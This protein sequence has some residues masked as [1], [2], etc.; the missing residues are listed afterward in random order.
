MRFKTLHP[1][2]SRKSKVLIISVIAALIILN[3]FILIFA[4]PQTFQ[5][6]G[7]GKVAKDFSA[8]YMAAWRLWHDSSGIYTPGIIHDGEIII[9]PQPQDYKYLPSFLPLITPL[10]LLNY[11]QGLIAFDIFQFALLPLTAIMLYSLFYRKGIVVILV[12]AAIFLLPFPLPHWGPIATYYWQW[13]EGQAKVF[14][15]FLFIL[16]F[17]LGFKG[18]PYASGVVFAFAAFDPRFAL[19]GLPLFL[20]YNKNSMAASVKTAVATLVIS[21]LILFYPPTGIGFLNMVFGKAFN[22][23]L[24]AYAF[25]PLLTLTA[26]L[27]VNSQEILEN[28]FAVCERAGLKKSDAK[29]D[30]EEDN[31]TQFE[32]E[33]A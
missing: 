16:S 4:Y 5:L 11:H 6:D 13:A 31:L 8:Y 32:S 29:I 2:Y 9:N 12:V 19:L 15:T 24:Y 18:K 26:L 17:Y 28:F 25:I 22:T 7:G 3:F 21:N 23:T 1:P 10:Q 14:E 33:K 27:L 20:F 30:L